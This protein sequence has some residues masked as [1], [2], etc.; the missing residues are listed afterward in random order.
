M[1]F[2][3]GRYLDRTLEERRHLNEAL[4]GRSASRWCSRRNCT[5]EVRQRFGTFQKKDDLEEAPEERRR[6]QKASD[7]EVSLRYTVGEGTGCDQK[8]GTAVLVRSIWRG[9]RL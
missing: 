4:E 3:K 8:E 2:K 9:D 6:L 1:K 5:S 7:G